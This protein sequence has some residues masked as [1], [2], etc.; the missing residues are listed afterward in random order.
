MSKYTTELRFICENYA[1]LTESVGGKGVPEVIQKAIPKVFDFSWPIFDEAYRNVLCTKILKHY[2]TREIGEE[3][4]GLWKL[5]LDVKL[6]EIMPYYNKLY[7]SQLLEFN[8][9]YTVDYHEK[10]DGK[11]VGTEDEEGRSYTATSNQ[12]E[13][14]GSS[15]MDE[16][17]DDSNFTTHSDKGKTTTS[18]TGVKSEIGSSTD[19]T[20]HNG[21]NDGNT[22]TD[23]TTST[24]T[25]DEKVVSRGQSDA[26][27][28]TPQGSLNGVLAGDYLTN[29][30]HIEEDSRTTDAQ[31]VTGTSSGTTRTNITDNWS[32]V[33]NGSNRVDTDTTDTGT[34]TTEGSG[35]VDSNGEHTMHR[36]ESD[37]KSTQGSSSEDHDY[38][39]GRDNTTTEDYLTH[40]Y[41]LHGGKTF[42]E[43]LQEYRDTFLNIDMMV[44]DELNTLFI[45]LW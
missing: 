10:R 37:S 35:Q 8:P 4:V 25:D 40:V 30:R 16:N 11:V 22:Y 27:S 6:N 17:G 12:S 36:N 28:D 42:M 39:K 9:L 29:A 44:I 14:S 26:Y 3:T 33:K 19:D 24:E 43:L 34:D 15:T 2:Y 32:E 45:N 13:T 23:A 31:T 38:T 1:G 5:R 41:G 7:E 18:K 21:S 20:T